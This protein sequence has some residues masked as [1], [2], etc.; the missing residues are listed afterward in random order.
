MG[1]FKYCYVLQF[2]EN[3]GLSVMVPAGIHVHN[4]YYCIH[5][6]RYLHPFKRGFPSWVFPLSAY[7]V[8]P[9]FLH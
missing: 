9:T 2:K 4:L 7:I 6:T 1:I 3:C 5:E 8:N